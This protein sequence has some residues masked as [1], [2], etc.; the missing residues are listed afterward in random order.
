M[1]AAAGR[2]AWTKGCGCEGETGEP[3]RAGAGTGASGSVLSCWVVFSERD[4]SGYRRNIP[5]FIMAPFYLVLPHFAL[6][7]LKVLK[8]NRSVSLRSTK[9]HLR[10]GTFPV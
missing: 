7:I 8:R 10:E 9:H 2:E 4:V 6:N 3:Q 1:A 5:F